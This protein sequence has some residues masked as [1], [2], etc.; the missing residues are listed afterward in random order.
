MCQFL[1]INPNREKTFSKYDFRI[2]FHDFSR[3][4][5]IHDFSRFSMTAGNMSLF[6]KNIK[7]YTLNGIDRFT[8]VYAC[9]LYTDFSYW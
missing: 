8:K 3:S 1:F 6:T 9:M 4:K 7:F 2:F 5:K